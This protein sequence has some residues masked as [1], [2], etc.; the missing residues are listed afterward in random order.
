MEG[1]RLGARIEIGLNQM[2]EDGSFDAMFGKHKSAQLRRLNIQQRRVIQLTNPQPAPNAS[3]V[4]REPHVP[5]LEDRRK[6]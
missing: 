5:I 6:Q 2:Q 3:E 1:L 4:L